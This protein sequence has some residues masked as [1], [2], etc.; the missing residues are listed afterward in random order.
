MYEFLAPI[1][2]RDTEAPEGDQWH[3]IGDLWAAPDGSALVSLLLWHQG[4]CLA[5]PPDESAKD[6]WPYIQ[7]KVECLLRVRDDRPFYGR[8]GFIYT[9]T[10]E[11]GGV[12]Y[13]VRL[14]ARPEVKW[15]KAKE[16]R[17]RPFAGGWLN[18][19]VTQ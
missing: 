11:H 6:H 7:G 13:T 1:A 14:K 4:T 15:D 8:V 17:V 10:P 19:E 3:Q 12:S 18:L 9:N 2:Y 16:E 5:K